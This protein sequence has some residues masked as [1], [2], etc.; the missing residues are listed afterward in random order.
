MEKAQVTDLYQ[1]SYLLLNGCEL[2]GIECIP[3]GKAVSCTL[4]FQGTEVQT[5]LEHWYE[6]NAVVN[7]WDF[8]TAY[9]Q[10]NS[11]IH[12]AKKSYSRR[13]QEVQR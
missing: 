1:A 10:I 6:K 5:R 4:Y 3:T 9:N 2:T 7:L 8:R 11:F 13:E 12:Q